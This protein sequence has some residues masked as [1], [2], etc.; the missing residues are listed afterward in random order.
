MDAQVTPTSLRT[1]LPFTSEAPSIAREQLRRFARN[2]RAATVDDA[3][4]MVSELVTNAVAHG[5]PEITL[6]LRLRPGRLTVA[7]ADRGEAPLTCAMPPPQQPFGRGLV[8]VNALAAR[9][10][11]SRSQ[12]G[13]DKR[14]WFDVAT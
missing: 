4:L 13:V 5:Q 7:V 6:W 8:I 1:E 14:V 2:L 3:V 10:G 11:V 9:W 12:G